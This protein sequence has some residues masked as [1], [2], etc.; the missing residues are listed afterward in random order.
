MRKEKIIQ[1]LM[2]LN[3][4]PTSEL[5]DLLKILDRT[6]AALSLLPAKINIRQVASRVATKTSGTTKAAIKV[7]A[8]TR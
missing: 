1:I 2:R 8:F 6:L 7:A 4:L 5:T 3:Q